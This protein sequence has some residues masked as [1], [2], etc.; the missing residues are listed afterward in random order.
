MKREYAEAYVKWAD[1]DGFN[2]DFLSADIV[3]YGGFSFPIL[4]LAAMAHRFVFPSIL[5]ALFVCRCVLA[6]ILKQKL[7]ELTYFQ[8]FL[9]L[10]ASGL[11]TRLMFLLMS[12]SIL[13]VTGVYGTWYYLLLV[14]VWLLFNILDFWFTWWRIQTGKFFE[15]QERVKE[16]EKQKGKQGEKVR[17]GVLVSAC[18]IGGLAGFFGR[19]F[20]KVFFAGVSQVFAVNFATWIL[21]VIGMGLGMESNTLWKAYYVKKYGFQGR[22]IPAYMPRPGQKQTVLHS[23]LRTLG[24]I[25]RFLLGII[26]FSVLATVVMYFFMRWLPAWLG[27][28]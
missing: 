27:H 9:N 8:K 28:R 18:I 4:G 5:F 15:A 6:V 13:E 7:C 26:A 2:L 20:A 11:F 19:R 1:S 17:S 22:S 25:G 12:L 21:L 3:I 14:G 23:I 10:G 24:V 16:R